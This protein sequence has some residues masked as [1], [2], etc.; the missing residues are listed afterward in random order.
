MHCFL[1]MALTL[2]RATI[3]RMKCLQ[4]SM[5]EF[6]IS[7]SKITPDTHCND[8]KH[9]G[10]KKVDI[11]EKI[12]QCSWI[13]ILYDDLFHEWKIIPLYLISKTFAKS[14][15]SPSNFSF[16]KNLIKSFPS[17]DKEILLNWKTFFPKTP[18]T[19]SSVLSQF[20]WYN[21]NI[22]IDEGDLHRFRFS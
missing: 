22:Q 21:I 7:T 8:Y 17:F 5:K 16:K 9:G 14:F 12:I 20:L 19:P 4:Y 11:R 2:M 15:I 6:T 10:L 1:K 18:E 13:K 3:V